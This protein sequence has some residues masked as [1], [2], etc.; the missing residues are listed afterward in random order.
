MFGGGS[1]TVHEARNRLRSALR[2]DGPD[3]KVLAGAL[4]ILAG[5]CAYRFYDFWTT[6]FFVS[7]EYGYF[8]D[9]VHGSIYSDRWF[10]GWMNIYLFKALGIT[11]VDAFSFLLPF[12]MFFWTGLTLFVFYK[13]LKFLGFNKVTVAV[14]LLSSFV[15]ISFVLLS[16]GFLTEPVGLCFAMLGIFFLL[17]FLKSKSSRGHIAFPILAVLSFGAA[18]GTREPYEAFLIGGIVIVALIA[19]SHRRENIRVSRAGSRALL[20]LCVLFFAVGS[21]FFLTVPTQA[22]SQQVQPLSTQLAES[23][24]TQPTT[25][26]P[27]AT[28]TVSTST[29][30]TTST[31]L[32][33]ITSANSTLTSTT[34]LTRTTTSTTVSTVLPAAVPFYRQSLLLNTLLIFLGGIILGWGPICFVVALCGFLILLR[35]SLWGG[36][37]TPRFMLLTALTALGSYF[38]V[39]FI[40]APDPSYFSFQDYSTIIRFS[41][42][43]LPAYFI[44]APYFVLTL[45]KSRRRLAGLGAVCIL[46]LLIAV[47]LYE[48]YASSN[49]NEAAQ[50]PF[51][52]GYRSDAVI[53]RNYFTANG[54]GQALNLVGVP[55]GWTF[56]PG[57]QDI[58]DLHAYA[59]GPDQTVPELLLGNFTSMKWQVFYIYANPPPYT[60]PP[61]SQFLVQ[62]LNSTSASSAT[63]P[64]SPFTILGTQ[65]VL[66]G[67]DFTLYKVQLGWR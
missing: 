15:L 46:F 11:N 5:L 3:A 64:S 36:D 25:S 43:A 66:S 56:T 20:L 49:F 9:A 40:F 59:T 22:Y 37:A 62:F 54:G 41:D 2:L 6:G 32:V 31:S 48:G 33:T 60:F 53:L 18:S 34:T 55:Y 21:V 4:T 1:G 44:A 39:S 26:P 28:T 51:Q 13:M 29:I 12:Y 7:D 8:F 24:V 67:S 65:P 16:L 30:T 57:V 52:L 35:R 23:F 50:N 42:T 38:V 58:R 14:S 61:N 63:P 17:R 47:P 10:F 19:F 27:A 45:S